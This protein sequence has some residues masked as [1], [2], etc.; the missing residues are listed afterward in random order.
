LIFS[1]TAVRDLSLSSYWESSNSA[2]NI[3]NKPRFYDFLS[4]F[5]EPAVTSRTF[6]AELE[7]HF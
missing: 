6:I 1:D 7:F 3:T 4:T 2:I 5:S